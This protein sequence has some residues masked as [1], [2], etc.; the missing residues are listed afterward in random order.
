MRWQAFSK[1]IAQNL[2]PFGQDLLVF[3]QEDRQVRILPG[4]GWMDGGCLV[5]AAALRAWSQGRLGIAA[6][7][8]ECAQTDDGLLVDHYAATVLDEDVFLLLDADGLGTVE[9]FTAKMDLEQTSGGFL[10]VDALPYFEQACIGQRPKIEANLYPGNPVPTLVSG[11]VQAFGDFTMDRIWL[12]W[13][14]RGL[15]AVV[16]RP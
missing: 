6:W 2:H 1:G 3:L 16:M 4:Y 8:R 14:E 5:L 7:M 9:D 10:V 12:G 15:D 11:L 13:P